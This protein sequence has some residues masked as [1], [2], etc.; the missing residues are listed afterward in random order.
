MSN[1][2]SL[3][4]FNKEGDYLNFNYND[5]SDRF[6]GDILFHEN[7]NDTYKTY[8][9]YMLEKVP[10][11]EFEFPGVLTTKKF[12]LFNEYGINFYGAKYSNQKIDYIEPTNNYGTFYSKWIYGVEFD[13][14][15]PIGTLI[16]F[17]SLFL[18][19]SNL[20][21]PYVVVSS[22]KGAIMV[23]G[24][25]DNDTFESTFK[26]IYEDL[27]SYD[28]KSIS[29]LNSLG[30]YDYVDTQNY[31]DNLSSWNEPSFYSNYF[32]GKK[33]NVVNSDKNDGIITV[34]NVDIVD[35]NHFEYILSDS[36]LP[37]NN[38]LIIEVITKTDLPK[39]IRGSNKHK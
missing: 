1:H 26:P 22:K 28:N 8:G 30:V 17:D 27:S 16:T 37:I 15:F 39:I 7:S 20:D 18:E 21:K 13:T 6:E 34:E 10:S 31:D 5:S 12:Q 4:F 35:V 29:G 14:K 3:A 23:I 25:I 32:T 24:Q 36:D 11:F 19:F 2:K 38:D 9:I 33:L